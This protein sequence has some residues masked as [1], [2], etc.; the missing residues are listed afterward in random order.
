MFKFIAWTTIAVVLVLLVWQSAVAEQLWSRAI[1]GLLI[2]IIGLLAGIRIGT[3]AATAYIMDV[4]RMN[5][6]LAEQNQA[7]QDAN[8]ILLRQAC[9]E[10]RVPSEA[11][12]S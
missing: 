11:R 1:A 8:T 4:Q 5:K 9:A 6:V 7:L 12:D 2:A 10:L 3:D